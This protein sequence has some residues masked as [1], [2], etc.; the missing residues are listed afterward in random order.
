MKTLLWLDDLRNPFFD[1][2]GKVPKGYDEISWV[3][4]YNNFVDFECR[5][6]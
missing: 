5:L 2:E 6:I 1:E 4:N 3:L